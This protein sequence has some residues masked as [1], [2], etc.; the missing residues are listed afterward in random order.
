MRTTMEDNIIITN[1]LKLSESERLEFK[2]SI[3]KNSV[4][5]VITSFINTK[6]GDLVIGINDD[7]T[8]SGIN[9]TEQDRKN[10]ETFLINEINP[11]A[12]VFSRIETYKKKNIILI[13]VWE[14]ANKPYYFKNTIYTR[15]GAETIVSKGAGIDNLLD[16]RKSSEQRWERQ[17]VLGATFDD[18]DL[19]EVKKSLEA[20]KNYATD[21]TI[22]DSESFLINRGLIVNGN[23][24]NACM[25][26]FGNNPTRFIP[27]SRIKLVVHPGSTSGDTFIENTV[28]EKNI[29]HNIESILSQFDSV[30]GK[31][32]KIEG[33]F[34]TEKKRYPEK[35][36]RE[37]LLNAI[38]H[39]DYS[40]LKAF[41]T[42]S[43]YSDRLVITNYGG[44]PEELTV[45]DLKTEHNSILRNP[46]IAQMCF[47]RR[48]I[49]MLGTGTLR[50]IRECK[51]EGFKTPVWKSK[52]NI[53]E[54]TFS[55]VN[56]Q[57][58]GVNEG[59]NEG[60][61]L[62]IEGV[63][64]GVNEEL[65]LLYNQIAKFPGKKANELNEQINKSLST[66]E[67]YLKILKEQGFIEFR[68]APKTGGY[69]LLK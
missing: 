28:F 50:M 3:D 38:V 46:D 16:E 31:E 19:V 52:D 18:L 21:T 26:L 58:E 25:V 55:G 53:L 7:K 15:R 48:Y 6:G 12:P 30:I 49:E 13:S 60:V 34:R 40:D 4:A 37:G 27:Q 43:I 22:I 39:R 41:L 68:G 69:H 57:Y 51:S 54:L 10:L 44:L 24:T 17:A 65:T 11:T 14:G 45:K 20:Y 66:T 33:A 64:E 59:V 35:A 9:P 5:K 47:Y 67:R 1:L 2:A 63:N 8:V 42:I 29:F 36:L 32:I 56:H 61:K 23:I 62:N